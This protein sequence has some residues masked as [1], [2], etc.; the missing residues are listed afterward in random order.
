MQ[1]HNRPEPVASARRRLTPR[2]RQIAELASY[3]LSNRRTAEV[4]GIPAEETAHHLASV[5][6]KLEIDTRSALAS[7]VIAEP[8]II[9]AYNGR[10]GGSAQESAMTAPEYVRY[11]PVGKPDPL[12]ART[13]SELED[14]LRSLWAWAGRPS[15]R[16]LAARSGGAFSHATVSK[17]IHEKP[18]KPALKLEY[19]LGF[20]RA[21]GADQAEQQ[22][23]ITAW[24]I[25][26]Q[27]L[28][29]HR[30]PPD[31]VQAAPEASRY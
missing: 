31:D 12:S 20:A 9:W 23:W 11:M 4:L 5:Y 17:L 6:A 8:D 26:T 16:K 27:R 25:I 14:H 3:G 10:E 15:S 29:N 22:R 30:R 19:V 7:A 13:L 21:C 18:R 24:R 28:G 2:E 1:S